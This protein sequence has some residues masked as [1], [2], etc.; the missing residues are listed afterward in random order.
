MPHAF[1]DQV[2][3][4]VGAI[5]GAAVA[6]TLF[7]KDTR[8]T[9]LQGLELCY[10]NGRGLMEVPRMLLAIAGKFPG[11]YK[12]NLQHNWCQIRS[13]HV[14]RDNVQTMFIRFVCAS[15]FRILCSFHHWCCSS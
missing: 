9:G 13:K 8:S 5:A 1:R 10:W 7:K 15:V 14:S 2:W 3:L 12:G 11:D 6:Y 4:G